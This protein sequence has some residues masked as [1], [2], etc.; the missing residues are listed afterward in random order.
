MTVPSSKGSYSI[1]AHEVTVGEYADWIKTSPS[2]IGQPPVCSWNTDFQPSTVPTGWPDVTDERDHPITYVDWCD[3]VAYC[4]A[5]ARRL[6]GRIGGGAVDWTKRTDANE[7]QWFNA[8][9][10]GGT[11]AYTYGGASYVPGLCNS[12]NADGAQR[13]TAAQSHP[14]CHA[15]E[16]YSGVYDLSGNVWEWED[17]CDSTTKGEDAKCALRGGAWDNNA[18]ESRCAETGFAYSRSNAD[19]FV[20]FRCCSL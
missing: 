4:A 19:G 20:G 6:C 9:T 8:C 2:V 10:S 13:V 14:D 3:A 11:H 18:S 12:G 17:A 15:T 1:D 5:H 16:A 7:S